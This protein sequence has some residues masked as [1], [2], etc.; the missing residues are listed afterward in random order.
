MTLAFYQRADV[1]AMLPFF[2][3]IVFVYKQALRLSEA[4]KLRSLIPKYN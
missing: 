2:H 3:Y 1:F 4:I